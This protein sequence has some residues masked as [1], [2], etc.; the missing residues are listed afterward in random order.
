MTATPS[1]AAPRAM[2]ARDVLRIPD[3]RRIFAGQLISDFGDSL[4][5]LALLLLVN[6]LTGSVA[7]LAVMAIVLAL[8]QVTIGVLAGVYVDRWDRRRVML[9]ADLARAGVVLGFLLVRTPDALW[10]LYLLGL[11]QASIGTFFTP[12]RTAFVP[13]FVPREGLLAANSLNQGGRL[14]ASVLGTGTAGVIVGLFGVTWPAFVLDSLTFVISFLFVLRIATPGRV[15]A[16]AGAATTGVLRSV[17]EGIR[18]VAG[19]RLLTGTLI[20]AGVV[21]LGLG[22]VNVLFVP[23]LINELRVPATWFGAI[24]LAQTSSMILSAAILATVLARVG[25]TRV[26]SVTLA[27][28]GVVIALL[29]GV[30]EVWQVIVLLFAV[31]WLITPLQAAVTTIV[32]TETTSAVRGRVAAL[33]SSTFQTASVASMAVAGIFGEVIGVRGVFLGAAGVIGLAT[34]VSVVLFRG[35]RQPAAPA[36]PLA[37]VAAEAS[38]ELTAAG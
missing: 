32:Q 11:V 29:A 22:A 6:E 17:V 10:L 3:F 33:L 24:E 9:V 18:V 25:A 1:L 15:A 8:P 38:A 19:S 27:G 12:A 34:V 4:T 37:D 20:S 23:L 16:A 35:V 36:A 13:R 2:S 28:T 30:S 14:V 31:G 5:M 7:A 21:M 26:I